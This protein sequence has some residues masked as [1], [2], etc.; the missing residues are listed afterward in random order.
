MK[1]AIAVRYVLAFFINN[2]RDIAV[3]SREV[4]SSMKI[5]KYILFF[6]L[7]VGL[8]VVGINTTA[9]KAEAATT[10][11]LGVCVTPSP[12]RCQGVTHY[13][14]NSTHSQYR[15]NISVHASTSCRTVPTSL[16]TY[17]ALYIERWWGWQWKAEDTKTS[18][19][20]LST[21][22][23]APHWYCKGESGKNS[24]LGQSQH[25]SVENGETY[26]GNTQHIATLTCKY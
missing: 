24:Y 3:R 23:A 5:V 2:L 21:A 7:A 25:R 17:S 6:S 10:C 15:W 13:V 20:K 1:I 14:H 11:F 16:R 9:S 4:F 22:D 18:T 19:Y 26:S 12:N 8:V